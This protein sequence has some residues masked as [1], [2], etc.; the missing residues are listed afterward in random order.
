M[1]NEKILG[2]LEEVTEQVKQG[3]V[4]LF[5]GA[6]ASH[7]AGGHNALLSHLFPDSRGD[8][9]ARTFHLVHNACN[10]C[11]RLDGGSEAGAR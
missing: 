6:G 8:S 4:A 5:L 11:D 1:E 10:R 3:K 2:Y 9:H 7:A